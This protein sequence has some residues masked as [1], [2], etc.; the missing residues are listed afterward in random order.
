MPAP[1]ASP[2]A[3]DTTDRVAPERDGGTGG[4]SGR[5]TGRGRRLSA[6]ERRA[7]I[8]VAARRVLAAHGTGATTDDIARAAGVSQPYV[9]R[10]FGSKQDLV[11]EVYRAAAAEVIA[12]FRAVA[13]GPEAG[14]R[15][16][17]AYIRLLADRDLLSLLMQGFTAGADPEVAAEARS[18]LGE[19]FRLFRDRTGASEG[20]ARDFVA[21]GMLLNVLVSTDALGHRDEHPGLDG[22]VACSL[23]LPALLGPDRER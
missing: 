5:G 17:E 15:M 14:Q 10:L 22:L 13:P 19:A 7:Q 8:L 9:V 18:T 3:A 12:A 11:L 23:D 1:T 4:G 21:Q 6:D 2:T 20:E 16:S